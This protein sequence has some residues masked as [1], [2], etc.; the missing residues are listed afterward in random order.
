LEASALESVS[1]ESTFL[2]VVVE[3]L[4]E[5]VSFCCWFF[6]GEAAFFGGMMIE[7]SNRMQGMERS[8]EFE[9]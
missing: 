2:I 7:W 8:L 3:L 5:L 4:L 6:F 9:Q 1:L